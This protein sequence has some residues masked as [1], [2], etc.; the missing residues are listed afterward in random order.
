VAFTLTV[1]SPSIWT[2][3]LGFPAA[4]F[5]YTAPAIFSMPLAFL[6]CWI[7]S[8]MD[9]SAAAEETAALFEAQ[10]LRSQTGIGAAAA[11]AH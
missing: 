10:Y 1:L 7:V 9:R 11:A 5:P 3:V 4:I 6:A 2:E 8:I